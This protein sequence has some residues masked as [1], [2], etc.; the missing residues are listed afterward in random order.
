MKEHFPEVFNRAYKVV[1][2]GDFIIGQ[3]TGD[4]DA[5]DYTSL[6]KLGFDIRRKKWDAHMLKELGLSVDILPRGVA[7]GSEAG[8]LLPELQKRFGFSR[9]T[10]VY[11][12]L[13]DN[14]AAF[15]ASGA[16][17]F[18]DCYSN[19]GSV[20]AI[21]VLQ[22][23][24][25]RDP[26]G[27]LYSYPH[28]EAG[29]LFGGSSCS[30]VES[31]KHY[32]GDLTRVDLESALQATRRNLFAYPLAHEGETL[33]FVD[34]RFRS[35][36]VGNP[37][38]NPEKYSAGVKGLAFIERWIYD[39]FSE[40]GAQVGQTV[41]SSGGG[42]MSPSWSQL[43][44]DILGKTVVVPEYTGAALGVAIL[45][46][47]KEHSTRLRDAQIKMTGSAGIFEPRNRSYDT[48]YRR[49]KEETLRRVS[50]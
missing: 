10:R 16:S 27:R 41:Y 37:K 13:V 48:E 43:R 45:V 1:P 46:A 18:G 3:L 33:P 25:V 4:F 15:L 44:A 7:P 49:F 9:I 50:S 47:S 12:G 31:L 28:P 23:G 30:G 40:M 6:L 34:S 17:E 26:S 14:N 32:V 38:G 11:R 39:V 24:L 5:S 21:K 2:E 36:E 35:F 19:L 42:T 29:Y 22:R 8:A 20:L